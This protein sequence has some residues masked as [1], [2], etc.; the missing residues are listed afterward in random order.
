M[1]HALYHPFESHEMII[2]TISYILYINN[3]LKTENVP[4]LYRYTYIW[5]CLLTDCRFKHL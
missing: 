5:R 3:V 1:P 4:V 2:E